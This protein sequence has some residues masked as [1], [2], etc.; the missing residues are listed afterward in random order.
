MHFFFIDIIDLQSFVDV[1]LHIATGD[2]D[3]SCDKLSDLKAV[4]SAYEPLI[5]Q[6]HHESTIEEFKTKCEDVWMNIKDHPS[7]LTSLVSCNCNSI[8][9]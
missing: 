7:L 1:A 8:I 2:G 3:F 6:I 9:I 4:A 5:F